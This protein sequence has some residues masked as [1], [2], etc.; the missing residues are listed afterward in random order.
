M[1]I[2]TNITRLRNENERNNCIGNRNKIL[3]K[4]NNNK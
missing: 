2:N 3:N 4:D 1:E